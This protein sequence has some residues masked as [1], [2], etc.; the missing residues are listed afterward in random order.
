MYIEDL[1][2][3]STQQNILSAD[4]MRLPLG[5]WA[6]AYSSKTPPSTSSNDIVHKLLNDLE[7]SSPMR[8][9]PGSWSS[10]TSG[11]RAN[12]SRF[13]DDYIGKTVSPAPRT[14]AYAGRSVAVLQPEDLPRATAQLAQI[15]RINKVREVKNLQRY[16]ERPGK[17][18]WRI[19][20]ARKRREFRAGMR[21]LFHLALQAQKRG[22]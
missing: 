18:K 13:V 4:E 22:L 21:M 12:R 3:K 11:S 2:T 8:P 1:L 20:M 16:H 6:R 17:A 5:S 7:P 10:L 14:G 9:R 15:N 19:R